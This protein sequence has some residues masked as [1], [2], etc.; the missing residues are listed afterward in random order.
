MLTFEL[1]RADNTAR[2][3]SD[4]GV[5]IMARGAYCWGCGRNVTVQP[6]GRCPNGHAA[7][8]LSDFYETGEP[9][10]GTVEHAY[11][12]TEQEYL[13]PSLA[14][15]TQPAPAYAAGGYGA[16]VYAAAGFAPARLQGTPTDF[17]YGLATPFAAPVLDVDVMGRRVAALLIDLLIVWTIQFVV[18]VTLGITAGVILSLSGSS[19]SGAGGVSLL[20]QVLAYLISFGYFIVLEA[21]WGRTVGKRLFGLMVLNA[22]GSQISWGEA[23]VRR[24]GFV[25]DMFFCGLLGFAV[26]SGSP[27]K[28]RVGDRWAK[29]VVVSAR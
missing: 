17:A 1:P 23:T 21:L 24:I 8:S 27:L 5:G 3:T 13:T 12:S 4:A 28:Q 2:G 16:P 29:T 19:S 14:P 7:E 20:A 26:A 25:V 10:A 22:D 18:A 9:E 11:P 6:D 15:A